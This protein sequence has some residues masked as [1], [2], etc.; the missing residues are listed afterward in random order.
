MRIHVHKTLE[1]KMSRRPEN[2][3]G[4]KNFGI[5]TG[6]QVE[7]P[8]SLLNITNSFGHNRHILNKTNTTLPLSHHF[9]CSL[10]VFV[11]FL[12]ICV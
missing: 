10:F 9:S 2:S 11:L 4:N 5:R 7:K 1:K 3:S 8:R 6:L 12:H